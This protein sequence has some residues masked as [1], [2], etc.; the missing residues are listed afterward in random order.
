MGKQIEK[1]GGGGGRRPVIKAQG[2]P[3]SDRKPV[4]DNR[5]EKSEPR[6]KWGDTTQQEKKAKGYDCRQRIPEK[7][8]QGGHQ[9][10]AAGAL[11]QS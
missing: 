11:G 8:Q 3:C 6:K 5:E 2:H 7:K 4:A 1:N 10:C 9:G